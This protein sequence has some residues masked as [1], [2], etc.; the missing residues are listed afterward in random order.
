[1]VR[2]A[3]GEGLRREE[4]GEGEDEEEEEDE[5]KEGGGLQRSQ[6]EVRE[7]SRRSA[8]GTSRMYVWRWISV[9]SDDPK[10]EGR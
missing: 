7:R 4:G 1:M 6:E 5:E 8:V 2:T 9:S 10:Q 3:E